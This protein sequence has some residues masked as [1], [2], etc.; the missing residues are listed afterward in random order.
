[1][2]GRDQIMRHQRIA[3]LIVAAV[4]LLGIGGLTAE[5][6]VGQAAPAFTAETIDGKKVALAD[7]KG[8]SAVPSGAEPYAPEVGKKHP[9]FTLPRIDSREPVSLSDFR[10]KKVLL[11]QFASW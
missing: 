8:K 11:M 3:A 5:P 6:K 7:Y 9:D 2:V 10:G 4:A 1:M